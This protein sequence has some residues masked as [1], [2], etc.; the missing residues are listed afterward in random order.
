[1]LTSLGIRKDPDKFMSRSRETFPEPDKLLLEEPELAEF[2][3]GALRE[4]FRTG[5]GGAKQDAAL[6]ARPW[7][8]RLHDI[9]ADVYL[10]HGEQDLNV[11]ISVGCYVADAL[12]N[13]QATFFEEE[14][15]LTLPYNHKQAIL[16]V[17]V[18]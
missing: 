3:I 2:F 9:A 6:Y 17:L 4:A 16:D 14:A 7:G 13:C 5:I 1:M 11:P 15:H 18:G 8:F 10:W 12:P